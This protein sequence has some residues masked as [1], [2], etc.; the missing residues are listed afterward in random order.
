M[1][2]VIAAVFAAALW[3]VAA[4]VAGAD[5]IVVIEATRLM[6][7]VLQAVIG[8]RVTFVNRSGRIVHVEFGGSPAGHRV[9]QIPSEIWAVFH[10]EGP[11]LYVVH[12]GPERMELRGVIEVRHVPGR[13]PDPPECGD[14]SVM[15]VCLEP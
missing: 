2:T 9:F 5:S 3:T 8:E 14:I 11:H 4:P 12:L 6:P 10:R 1:R 13:R 7:R 15:E